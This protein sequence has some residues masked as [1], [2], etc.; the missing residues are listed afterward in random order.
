MENEK[1]LNIMD[2]VLWRLHANSSVSNILID[3]CLYIDCNLDKE[4]ILFNHYS[5]INAIVREHEKICLHSATTIN[6]NGNMLEPKD[7]LDSIFER[8][9][10]LT[11]G[12]VNSSNEGV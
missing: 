1:G 4:D 9:Y 3:A 8:L 10:D 6:Q 2:E 7:S 11:M 12:V 5:N